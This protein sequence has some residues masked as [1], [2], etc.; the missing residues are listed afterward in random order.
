VSA[1][2]AA[3]VGR[4]READVVIID[5]LRVDWDTGRP[6]RWLNAS[7]DKVVA[8]GL[9]TPATMHAMLPLM[10][11]GVGGVVLAGYDDSPSSLRQ[12]L[13]TTRAR[14]LA[15]RAI[16]LLSPELAMLPASLADVLKKALFQP[17]THATAEAVCREA[18]AARRSC[19]RWTRQAGIHS[20]GRF[21]RAARALSIV[22]LL[23][24]GD[25]TLA[26]IAERT[27]LVDGARVAKLIREI[28]VLPASQLQQLTDGAILDRFARFVR[29]TH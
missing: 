14:G 12:T 16:Q 4:S 9:A 17:H 10:R 15:Q 22:T 5:P 1:G 25:F 2:G 7:I 28:F 20:L 6:P 27:G 13:E 3:I 21:L 18:G 29:T 8:Y 24:G 23:R 26:T 19:D 11:L